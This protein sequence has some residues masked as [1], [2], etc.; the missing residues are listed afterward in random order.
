MEVANL[1][2]IVPFLGTLLEKQVASHHI[3]D[4]FA[5]RSPSLLPS[6]Q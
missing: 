5:G 6:A 2:T 1:K 3:G 4:A